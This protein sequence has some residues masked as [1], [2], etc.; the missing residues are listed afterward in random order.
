M[1]EGVF[2]RIFPNAFFDLAKAKLV[3]PPHSLEA[4]G[5]KALSTPRNKSFEGRN[6][7]SEICCL[8]CPASL[9]S[10]ILILGLTC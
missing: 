10:E 9:L 8:R 2:L 3:G 1:I 7:R 6:W 4:K 5:A